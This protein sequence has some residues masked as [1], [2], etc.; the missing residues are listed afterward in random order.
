MMISTLCYIENNGDWLMLL[1]NK[2]KHDVNKGKWIGVGG[3]LETGE[4]PEE[5]LLREIREE[6][7]LVPSSYAYRG[8]LS[9]I[10][11]DREPEYIFTYTAVSESRKF[12]ECD[13]GE[14]RWIPISEVPGLPL[15]EGDRHMLRL[16]VEDDRIFSL[17]LVYDREDRL[18]EA[19]ELLP[20]KKI[21][22]QI[23]QNNE[24]VI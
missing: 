16:M 22:K 8:L 15:W 3:K 20:E 5:C 19:L 9:F 7:G 14:L 24:I 23:H 12:Q 2:K 18:I 4:T 21:L 11:E 1:R 10:Y 13:E 17:K 6:T